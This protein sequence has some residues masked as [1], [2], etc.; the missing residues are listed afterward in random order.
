MTPLRRK[1]LREATYTLCCVA[2]VSVTCYDCLVSLVTAEELLHTEENPIWSL[3]LFQSGTVRSLVALKVVGILG[4]ALVMYLI[5]RDFGLRFMVGLP[6]LVLQ[7]WL[8][9]YLNWGSGDSLFSFDFSK[10]CEL[11]NLTV[12]MILRSVS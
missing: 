7:T 5:R 3:F 2:I 4:A 12:E 8:F 9:M 6:V 1:I 11:L 10:P